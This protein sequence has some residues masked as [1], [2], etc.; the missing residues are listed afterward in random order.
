MVRSVP[1]FQNM[2]LCL[3]F[4]LMF[5]CFNSCQ[6]YNFVLFCNV[7]VCLWF[8]IE[9][10]SLINTMKNNSKSVAKTKKSK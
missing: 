2:I 5:S 9:I 8:L 1:T 7:F 4:V 10:S 3:L 6:Q